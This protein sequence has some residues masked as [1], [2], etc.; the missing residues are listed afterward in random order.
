ML[1][2]RYLIG[3][4]CAALCW[5]LMPE[6]YRVALI[7]PFLGPVASAAPAYTAQLDGDYELASAINSFSILLSI[8]LIV[9]VL[10]ITA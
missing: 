9:A 10:L 1:L 7:I 8:V 6:M 2:P 4:A 3:F 5:F